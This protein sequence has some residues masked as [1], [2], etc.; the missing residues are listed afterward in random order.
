MPSADWAAAN[1]VGISLASYT[2]RQTYSH[3]IQNTKNI[4]IK[5]Y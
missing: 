3:Q 1:T 5:N 4:Q 2:D